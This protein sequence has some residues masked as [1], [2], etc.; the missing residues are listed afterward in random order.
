MNVYSLETYRNILIQ[1]IDNQYQFIRFETKDILVNKKI[2]ILRHDVDI[3]PIMALRLGQIEFELDVKANYFFQIGAETYNIFSEENR[4]IIV[5]LRQLNHSVGLHVDENIFKEEDTSIGETIEWFNRNVTFI[6]NIVSF[7]RPT[8]K[9]LGKKFDHFISAYQEEFFN[10]EKYLSDSRKN[11]DFYPKLMEWIQ[12]GKPM[13][14]LLLHPVWWCP[15]DNH[16]KILEA[17]GRRRKNELDVYLNSN[18][19][20][21][22]GR[23]IPNNENRTFGL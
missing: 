14:Q 1:A 9:V 12:K 3:S 4:N 22:F 10:N 18:F 5:A 7:H 13:I 15:E 23:F 2:F 6:D 17:I 16:E 20:K 11:Q 21:V 8:E 19:K